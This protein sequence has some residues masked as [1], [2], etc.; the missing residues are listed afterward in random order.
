MFSALPGSGLERG[1]PP[2]CV[3]PPYPTDELIKFVSIT[4]RVDEGPA[5]CPVCPT[6]FR[7]LLTPAT[8][9]HP[10]S[11]V[12]PELSPLH[13][14]LTRQWV[15]DLGSNV[16]IFAV[17]R[18]GNFMAAATHHERGLGVTTAGDTLNEPEEPAHLQLSP[19]VFQVLLLSQ[20]PSCILRAPLVSTEMSLEY[21]CPSCDV[22]LS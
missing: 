3:L 6:W 13:C 8:L 15:T 1:H 12:A 7:G 19:R 14:T 17:N 18:K 22:Q 5:A 4:P 2:T 21:P 20:P 11:T 9:P 16:T 10:C